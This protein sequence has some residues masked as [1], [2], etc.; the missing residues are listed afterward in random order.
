MLMYHGTCAPRNGVDTAIKAFA[1]ARQSA[2]HLVFHIQGVGEA[3]PSLKQLAHELR[4]AEHVVFSGYGPLEEVADFVAHG[5]IGIIAYPCDGFMNLVLPT[6]AYE[7]S[8]M[9][10]PMIAA[11]TSA[12][13]WMFRPTSLRLCRA[14]DVDSFAEAMVELYG[15]PETRAG[16]VESAWEDY[17]R[18]RW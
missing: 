10:R 8:W 9:R 17:D 2:P 13:R 6:K 16:L 11:S 7:Y 3:V 5:D 18:F 15:H 12:I 14:S 4:V 1:K